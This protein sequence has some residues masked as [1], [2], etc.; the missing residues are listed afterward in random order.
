LAQGVTATFTADTGTDTVVADFWTIL[1]AAAS[2]DLK[3]IVSLIG[4]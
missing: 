3:V 2:K 4:D 1:L